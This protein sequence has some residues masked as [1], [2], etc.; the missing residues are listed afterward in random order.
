MPVNG[1]TI[2]KDVSLDITGPS[3]P[4]R[5]NIRT[6]FT[7]KQETNDIKVKRAD[8][9]VDH[10]VIPDGWTGSFDYT[11]QDS[12]LDDYFA[13]L[14]Q[15]YYSGINNAPLTITE[16][17]TEANGS[18]SQYRYTRV[19]LKYDDAGAKTGDDVVK[20]KI[21]FMASRRLKV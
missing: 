8:G 7:A 12:L 20:Q 4:L 21:S 9:I 10:L 16:T 13:G 17:I 11:R 6:G 18:V 5:F 14:E 19:V 1:Y 2:G 15:N 3:G